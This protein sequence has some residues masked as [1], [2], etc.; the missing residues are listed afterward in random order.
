VF[1]E[2]L[3]CDA[4]CATADDVSDP[5]SKTTIVKTGP[6]IRLDKFIPSTTADTAAWPYGIYSANQQKETNQYKTKEKDWRQESSVLNQ[7][8]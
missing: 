2:D 7:E 8:P 3:A 4:V 5:P 6:A 1:T